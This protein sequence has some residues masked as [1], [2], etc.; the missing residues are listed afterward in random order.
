MKNK[1]VILLLLFVAFSRIEAQ[2]CSTDVAFLNATDDELVVQSVGLSE[3]KKDATEMA[4]RSAFYTL[5]YRGING[6]NNNKPLVQRDNTYYTEKF[7]TERYPMF[8]RA[9]KEISEVDKV[10]GQKTR[11]ASRHYDYRP[12]LFQHPAARCLQIR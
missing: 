9:S 6:Y 3:K 10:Q 2:E 5:F 4:V 1:I 11:N 7:L 8:V 12:P